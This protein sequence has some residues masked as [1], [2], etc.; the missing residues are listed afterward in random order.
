MAKNVCDSY[1]F[2]FFC[3]VM[4]ESKEISHAVCLRQSTE[5]SSILNVELTESPKRD[6]IKEKHVIYQMSPVDKLQSPSFDY[7]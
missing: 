6:I 7:M 2:Y 1:N 4:W 3:L 5:C